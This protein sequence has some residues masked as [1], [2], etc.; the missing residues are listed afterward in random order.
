MKLIKRKEKEFDKLFIKWWNSPANDLSLPNWANKQSWTMYIEN[1][2]TEQ[3]GDFC[4]NCKRLI[5]KREKL[6]RKLFK[7]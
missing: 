7:I 4:D 6:H 2:L 1:Y 3:C 5:K